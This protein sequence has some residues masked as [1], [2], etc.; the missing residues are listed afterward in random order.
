MSKYIFIGVRG[1]FEMSVFEL[2][3]VDCVSLQLEF[4][5]LIG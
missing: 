3:R 2:A 4:L 1:C 5:A